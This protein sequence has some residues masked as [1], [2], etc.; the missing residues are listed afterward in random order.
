MAGLAPYAAHPEKSRGR[1]FEEAACPARSVFQRD[2]D[3]IVHSNAFRR[4]IHKTQVFIYHEGDHYRTRLTHSLEVAQIARTLARSLGLNEDLVEAVALAHDLGHTPFGHAGEDALNEAMKPIGG[5]DHNA[6]SLRIV[7]YLEHRYAAFRGLNLT[8]ETLEGIVKHNGP[9]TLGDGTPS[10]RYAGT[11]LP[12]AIRAYMQIQDLGLST[13]CSLEGQIAALADDI[14]YNN[15]D[16]DDGFR[17]GYIAVNELE[18]V[19][20][21]SRMLAAVRARYGDLADAP[22]VY[23]MNRRMIAGMVGDVLTE[24]RARIAEAKP[25]SIEDVRQLKMPLAGFSAGMTAEIAE[26]RRFLFAK[27]YRHPAIL[28]KMA[29]AQAMLLALYEHFSAHPED[30]HLDAAS[31]AAIAGDPDGRQRAV[32]DF[33]A[34][35]TD[36]FAIKTYSRVFGGAGA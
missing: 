8:F 15:H 34:G 27:V 14:A 25:G 23:E 30:M 18:A 6:Q 1:L 12:H 26:L 28:E 33:V 31:S 16:I 5:F 10:G 13:Y 3:R 19:P 22:L 4:L 21:A 11:G 7:T 9:L 24:T 20:M 36:M 2:R 35:M 17:A 32:G 29:D